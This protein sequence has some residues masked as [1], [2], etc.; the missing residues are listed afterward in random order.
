MGSIY[1]DGRHYDLMYPVGAGDIKFWLELAGEMSGRKILEVAC[2]TGRIAI[3]LAQAGYQ[4]SGID[5]SRSMLDEALRKARLA[6]VEVNW[7]EG[8]M[9]HFDLGERFSLI[10]LPSNTLCHL[11]DRALIESFLSCVRRHLDRE[12]RFV[13]SVFVPD[14]RMLNRRC[15]EPLPFATYQN[16]EGG[17]DIVVSHT[18]EY[19]P[20][21]QIK[22]ITTLRKFPGQDAP[23]KGSLD[24]K[25]FFPQELDALLGYNGFRILHKWG[26]QERRPF[27][28]DSPLQIVVCET[29]VESTGE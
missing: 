1:D 9:R 26:D 27:G 5:S 16:P 22:R 19:E 13:L 4:V 2:G 24:L 14:P 7:V 28:A 11:H 18:Y 12:G 23:V 29:L 8:D 25:M 10:I 17:E 21:S 6:S 3:P 20:N 15:T